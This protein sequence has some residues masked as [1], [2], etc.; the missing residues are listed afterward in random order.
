MRDL[1]RDLPV[2]AQQLPDFDPQDV[3]GDPFALFRRWLTAAIDAGAVEPHAVHLATVDADGRPDLRVV[4]L[5][6]V[7][8][9]GWQVA[10]SARSAK[11]RQLAGNPYAALNFHWR[12]QARQVRVR[13]VAE[14]ADAATNRE[15]FLSRSPGSR[16]AGLA[17]RQSDVLTDRAE[18]DLEFARQR[19]R[20]AADP[21]LANPDHVRYTVVPESV[22]FWQ[23]DPER[24]H[25]RLRY[26]RTGEGWTREL[27]WP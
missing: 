22:E 8:A 25:T 24:R 10:T 23:G 18:L 20:V 19:E 1:L 6:D 14:P 13:G 16:I 17:G 15:D 26:R 4:I 5:R 11:G 7:D 9:A 12:E 27:L 3:P 2:F 21:E